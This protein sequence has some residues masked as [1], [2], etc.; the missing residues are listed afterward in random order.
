M[1]LYQLPF[2]D[3]TVERVAKFTEDQGQRL[4]LTNVCGFFLCQ[5]GT[6]DVTLNDKTFHLKAGDVY[7]YLPSTFISILNRS[8]DLN[9]IAIKCDVEFVLPMLEQLFDGGNIVA[10]REAPCIS[11]TPEQQQTIE[12]LAQMVLDRRDK[13][14]ASDM[15]NSTR[16]ILQQL[17][18]SLAMSL[19]HELL[20][21]YACNQSLQPQIHDNRDRIFQTFLVSLFH[22]YK[23]EREVSF[24]AAEQYLTPRYFSS[25]VKEK[26]GHSALQW[27]VQ[28]VIGSVKQ[29]LVTSDKSIK[30]IAL[31]YHFPS[32]SFFGKYFKQYTGLS[33]KEF[34]RQSR[35]TA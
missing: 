4:S 31:E 10:M 17:T 14:N 19:F 32:Q 22:N 33:P 6:A 12:N 21:D 2:E 3:I 16:H 24:Y 13:L 15:E 34:R 20:L 5:Q 11:L 35:A 29:V 23:Q 1:S 30:E 7:F 28:M 8:S 27:I 9:G 25:A 26:S 18:L